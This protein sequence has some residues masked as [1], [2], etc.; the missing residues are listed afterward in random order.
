VLYV[1][2]SPPVFGDDAI[3]QLVTGTTWFSRLEPVNKPASGY[4]GQYVAVIEPPEVK[5][6]VVARKEPLIGELMPRE[7]AAEAALASLEK[8]LSSDRVAKLLDRH[9]VS[10]IMKEYG[11]PA[12]DPRESFERA[13]P[14]EPMLVN[15]DKGAYFVVPLA[16]AGSRWEGHA[17][18]AVAINAYDGSFQELGVFKPMH[19]LNREQVIKTASR[20]PQLEREGIV[21]ATP[22]FTRSS[23]AH[24][25][26]PLWQVKTD[27]RVHHLDTLGRLVPVKPRL[28]VDPQVERPPLKTEQVKVK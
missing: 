5:G 28:L 27:R 18:A 20:L 23:H 24:R 13:H 2:P 8:L 19:Y 7:R 10:R 3:I 6:M 4:H 26:M 17:Q 15:Q 21:D 25:L 16:F 12:A 11:L 22:V 14:L 1:D 9:D